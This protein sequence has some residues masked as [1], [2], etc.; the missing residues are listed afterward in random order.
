MATFQENL[1]HF[2]EFLKYAKVDENGRVTNYIDI[3][4]LKRSSDEWIKTSSRE[5]QNFAQQIFTDSRYRLKSQPEYVPFESWEEVFENAYNPEVIWVEYKTTRRKYVIQ[6]I[7]TTD[8]L[9]KDGWHPFRVAFA[10][11]VFFN[12]LTKETK[13]FGKLKNG[14]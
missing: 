7:D 6:G 5:F 11:I 3:E 14:N 8:V 2:N 12:P 1:E 4:F 13:P 9:I 10:D